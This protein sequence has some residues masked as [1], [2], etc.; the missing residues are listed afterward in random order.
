MP[1]K[2][3]PSCNTPISD[4]A[5][6]CSQCGAALTPP[7]PVKPQKT[8]REYMQD[9]I[10]KPSTNVLAYYRPR[11]IQGNYEIVIDITPQMM[12]LAREDK[13]KDTE[14]FTVWINGQVAHLSSEDDDGA[15]N[16]SLVRSPL[17]AGDTIKI[18][19]QADKIARKQIN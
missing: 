5:K 17:V 3:C 2:T 10:G 7:P 18:E 19:L 8:T 1:S 4:T 16:K 11:G 14:H 15:G 6:F 12:I 13:F 9:Q